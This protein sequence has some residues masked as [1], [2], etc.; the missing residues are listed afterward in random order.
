MKLKIYCVSVI[1]RKIMDKLPNYIIPLGLGQNQFPSN[2]LDE[3]KGKNIA[4]LNNHYGEHSGIF[5]VWKNCMDEFE[6]DDWIGFSHYRKLWLNNLYSKKQK[7]NISSVYSNLLKQNN[8]IF[9][10]NDAI[11]IQPIIYSNKNLLEDFKEVHKTDILE[12]CLNFLEDEEKYKFKKHLLSNMLYPLNLFIVK[13]KFFIKY[14]EVVFPWLEKSTNLCKKKNLLNGYNIRLPS[15]LSERFVSYW[16]SQ[17]E[18]KSCL[19]YARLGQFYL[20]N[21]TNKFFNPLK[22]PFTFRNYPTIHR[23]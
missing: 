9:K 6:D 1:H 23:Y 12:E 4:Y 10:N 8:E 13:K 21:F 11:L 7:K 20:S 18:N 15:F 3:K 17:F 2:W 5:W 22:L 14:C 16:F 19:S